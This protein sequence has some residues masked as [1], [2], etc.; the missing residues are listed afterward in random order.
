MT[1]TVK[2]DDEWAKEAADRAANV[3]VAAMATVVAEHTRDNLRATSYPSVS[4]PGD[5]PSRD[6]GQLARSV[7]TTP[8]ENG[9][10]FVGTNLKYGRVL[11]YG[12]II[13]AKNKRYLTVP[14]IGR[15]EWRKIIREGRGSLRDVPGLFV[16]RSK[17]GN[18]LIG[19]TIGK[20]KASRLEAVAALKQSVTIAPRPWLLR[21]ANE[22][23]P[24]ARKRFAQAASQEM[25]RIGGQ[26]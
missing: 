22:A 15:Q 12:G 11:E 20:G 7:T 14:T 10:A 4:S 2:W 23:L 5:M 25:T 16:F 1:A 21:S 9:V 17:R 19:R 26:A 24:E 6:Q 18:L 3:G 8:V 13:S